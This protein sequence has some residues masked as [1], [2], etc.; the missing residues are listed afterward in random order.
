MS[1]CILE[2]IHAGSIAE[3]HYSDIKNK[4]LQFIEALIEK[5][6]PRESVKITFDDENRKIHFGYYPDE[7]E[8][9]VLYVDFETKLLRDRTTYPF[10]SEPP[11]CHYY[12][13]K[14]HKTI[15][16]YINEINALCNH[17]ESLSS[18]ENY[19]KPTRFF[20][21]ERNSSNQINDRKAVLK[22]LFEEVTLEKSNDFGLF[23][24]EIHHH[25]FPKKFLTANFN[26][27]KKLGFKTLFFEFLLY[28]RHQTLLDEYFKSDSDELPIELAY[29]LQ[30]QERGASRGLLGSLGGYTNIVKSA[31]KAGIRIVALDSYASL[32]SIGLTPHARIKSFN[33]YAQKIIRKEYG[34]N[35]Y[36]VFLG[37]YHGYAK[38]Y[39]GIKSVAEFVPS[40]CSVFL[41]DQ[42]GSPNIE[43]ETY[44][45]FFSKSQPVKVNGRNVEDGT[46]WEL[47]VDIAE[48][49]WITDD[50]QLQSF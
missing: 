40:S 35:P 32:L 29:Y 25:K 15:G 16:D 26:Y 44:F 30:Y 18:T 37:L 38:G 8:A 3:K 11:E 1:I 5:G 13:I 36:L 23:F 42:S 41:K 46:N 24:N 45:P 34:G 17:Y 43:S 12:R 31:K 49:D 39:Y 2:C 33:S 19:L 20:K 6:F 9:L 10:A 50:Y 28:E 21:Q 7:L 22:S 14:H 48:V 47:E 27:F 4:Y